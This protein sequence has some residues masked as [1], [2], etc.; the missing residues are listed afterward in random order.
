MAEKF[1]TRIND[2]SIVETINGAFIYR[3]EPS[4]N[5]VFVGTLAG[6]KIKS[7][8]KWDGRSDDVVI[9]TLREAGKL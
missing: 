4:T 7:F 8:Y 2:G 6:G 9:K 1:G 5:T 3:F